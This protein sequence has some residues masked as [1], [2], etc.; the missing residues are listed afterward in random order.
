MVTVTELGTV[1]VGVRG[2][3]TPAKQLQPLLSGRRLELAAEG[4][5]WVALPELQG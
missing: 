5:D 4:T 2:R 3:W 1:C